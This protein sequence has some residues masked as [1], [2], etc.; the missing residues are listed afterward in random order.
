MSRPDLDE[1]VSGIYEAALGSL[2]WGALLPTVARFLGA[3]RGAVGFRPRG[4]Q[5]EFVLSHNLDPGILTR[6]MDEFT[7]HDPWCEQFADRMRPGEFLHGGSEPRMADVLA[8]EVYSEIF[9]PVGIHDLLGITMAAEGTQRAYLSVYRHHSDKLFDEDDLA[10]ARLLAPHLVRAA[11]IQQRIGALGQEREAARAVLECVPYGVL[12]LD[13]DRTLIWANR[14][15]E[16]FLRSDSSLTV[17]A[18]VVR[19]RESSLDAR[20]VNACEDALR[21]ADGGE[22]NPSTRTPTL[23]S[24]TGSSIEIM[25][26]PVAPR[27]RES[28]LAFTVT[29]TRLALVLADPTAPDSLR[30]DAVGE[31]LQLPSALARLATSISS[32]MTVTEYAEKAGVTEGTARQQLKDL[33]L[34]VGVSRQVDLVRAVLRS[35]AP[36]SLS[37]SQSRS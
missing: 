32:G 28:S 35:V 24:A 5:A 16:D 11:A 20:L 25:V 31:V 37:D 22:P 12:L 8:T 34:R 4:W 17:R 14:R 36:L 13:A 27:A 1:V 9:R 33:F 21:I 30:A 15:A 10:R 18:G 3:D 6:W 29:P 26:V 19:A 7:G 23:R 2:E